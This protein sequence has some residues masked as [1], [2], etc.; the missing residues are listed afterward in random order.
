MSVGTPIGL[1]AVLLLSYI[2]RRKLKYKATRTSTVY[3][4]PDPIDPFATSVFPKAE[5]DTFPKAIAELEGKNPPRELDSS[6]DAATNTNRSSIFSELEGSQVVPPDTNDGIPVA[7][8]VTA[9]SPHSVSHQQRPRRDNSLTPRPR[10][11]H[12]L[13]GPAPWFLP[14]VEAS[15]GETLTPKPNTDHMNAQSGNHGEARVEKQ[16]MEAEGLDE[17]KQKPNT[18]ARQLPMARK[19][20]KAAQIEQAS[21]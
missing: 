1:F 9:G 14:A 16:S 11:S 8:T 2:L 20:T 19:H 3:F 7:T 5:L 6:P 13:S 15:E 12:R 21:E 10:A 4:P 17:G 18:K